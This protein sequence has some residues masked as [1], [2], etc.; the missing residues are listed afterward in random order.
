MTPPSNLKELRTFLGFIQYLAKFIPNLAEISAPLRLLLEKNV[1]WHWDSAQQ[2]SF[3]E[4]KRLVANTPVLG[5]YNPK[6]P[7]VLSVDA[8]STGLGA[9]LLQDEQP[10]AYASRALTE[11]QQKHAQ[12]EKE[13]LAILYGLQKFHQYV[14]GKHVT[15]ESD[16]KPL[17]HI[18]NRSL[19]K[20]PPRI[21]RMMMLLL[22][23]DYT[24]VYK[25]GDEMYISDALS[26][27]YSTESTTQ[28]EDDYDINEIQMDQYLPVNTF[29]LHQ[30]FL[31]ATADDPVMTKLQDVVLDGWP[32]TKQEL[33]VD[34]RE[35][36]N[37]RHE[38]S[39]INGLLFRGHKVIVPYQL[40]SSM[41][42]K[43]H[44]SHLGIVKCKQ[45]AREVLF[46]PGMTSQIE[47]KV[48]SCS[49]C[50]EHSRQNA[51]EPMVEAPL[52]ERPWS[53]IGLD[54]F[55][56]NNTTYL[57]IVDYYS[58]WPEIAKLNSLTSNQIIT[59]LKSQISRYG[60][61]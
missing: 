35:Y 25:P 16:H 13:T 47:D 24:V 32:S 22:K 9:V 15:V 58:K 55:E 26:R 57:L 29:L 54:L 46:W 6:K 21:Q 41:L 8:S 17:E 19:H 40:R 60:Y 23:Y 37:F 52:P 30:S 18:L 36:W 3:T 38:I 10:I 33:P 27:A 5:Y 4:L 7:V 34:V 20:A 11:S 50:N 44:E 53:K 39:C 59:Q 43:I 2:E 42:D 49:I 56:L 31:Q 61:T 1:L 12:I 28:I 51:K 45:R 14:Y 48:A